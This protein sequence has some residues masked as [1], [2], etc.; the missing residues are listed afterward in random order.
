MAAKTYRRTEVAAYAKVNLSLDILGLDDRRYHVLESIMQTIPLCDSVVITSAVKGGPAP[1]NVAVPDRLPLR[2]TT[3]SRLIPADSR[4]SAYR[5]AELMLRTYPRIM[6]TDDEITV[7]IK[8]RIPVGGG[9]GGSSADCAAVLNGFNTHF[10]LGLP[11]TQLA[12]LGSKL[13]SDVPFMVTGGTALVSGTGEVVRQ[14]PPPESCF[15]L[16]CFPGYGMDTWEVYRKYDEMTIP[17]EAR[18]DTAALASA[19]E[20]GNSAAFFAGL[21]NVLEVP[22]F[23]LNKK[24]ATLKTRLEQTDADKVLMSGSGSSFFCLF[25]KESRARAAMALL[26]SEGNECYTFKF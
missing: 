9:L 23:A 16:I 8:K 20:A 3:D 24:L 21:K 15:M 14:L 12:A 22:A 7:N 6:G 26:E 25:K 13:G 18:P 11:K 10:G 2:V 4:N 5:A 1:K 19:L 17:M